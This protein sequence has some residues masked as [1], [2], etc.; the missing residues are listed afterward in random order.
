MFS[1]CR[2]SNE[3]PVPSVYDEVVFRPESPPSKPPRSLITSGTAILGSP[4]LPTS[5]LLSASPHNQTSP[6]LTSPG[7]KPVPSA[8]HL[9]QF[10][11]VKSASQPTDQAKQEG[12]YAEPTYAMVDEKSASDSKK[13]ST[14][15]AAD[16]YDTVTASPTR[17]SSSKKMSEVST[18]PPLP[19]RLPSMSGIQQI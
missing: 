11:S 4:E 1:F 13:A 2:T 9:F 19:A 5:P 7:E 18:P 17:K 6:P 3:V 15:S 12:M 8:Y 10:P 16:V 14:D